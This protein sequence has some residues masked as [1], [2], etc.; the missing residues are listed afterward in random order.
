MFLYCGLDLFFNYSQN[1]VLSK[2]IERWF[3][4]YRVYMNKMIR[5]KCK[6]IQYN[7]LYLFVLL[8]IWCDR[9]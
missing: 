7:L 4:I 6:I 8:W 2:I 9:Y 1:T 5:F 3:H